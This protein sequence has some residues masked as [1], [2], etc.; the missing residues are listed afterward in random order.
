MQLSVLGK[1]SF[2]WC[3]FKVTKHCKNRG[4]PSKRG[5]TI[6][7]TQKLCS[8]ENTI[9]IVF[10]LK[11]SFVDMKECNLKSKNLPKIG[12]VCQ[13]A[14]SFFLGLCFFA[15]WWFCFF[16]ACAFV[17]VF[18]KNGPKRLFSCN[19]RGFCLFCS[20]ERPVLKC[21]FS[22]YSVFFLVFLFPSL[23]KSFFLW[24]LSINPFLEK[25]LCGGFVCHFI[26]SFPFL[27]FASLFEAIS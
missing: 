6:C 5:F 21:F 14:K 2:F 9:F 8:S 3:P 17:L 4:F 26:L 12:V 25:I 13:N 24:F 23:S 16:V 19:F 22:S 20:P 11:H 1:W 15:F 18:C 10:S 27:M 7:D